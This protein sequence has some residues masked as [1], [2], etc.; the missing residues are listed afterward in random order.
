ML[1]VRGVRVIVQTE[2]SQFAE[3]T[4]ASRGWV[5]DLERVRALARDA[6]A[7]GLT[8]VRIHSRNDLATFALRVGADGVWRLFAGAG[9]TWSDPVPNAEFAKFITPASVPKVVTPER[10]L[11]E[12][13]LDRALTHG[14]QGLARVSRLL[15]EVLRQA[16]YETATDVLR[17]KART[18][19]DAAAQTAV[20]AAGMVLVA[21]QCRLGVSR[22]PLVLAVAVLAAVASVLQIVGVTLGI[23]WGCVL[24]VMIFA[25]CALANWLTGR[26]DRRL[27][28]P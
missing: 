20:L 7:H 24:L 8:E 11:T 28:Q 13:K 21:I 9:R 22:R 12:D 4:V 16:T 17:A 3:V 15:P 18:P 19:V 10:A 25:G 5:T 26:L 14:Q 23:G 2:E 6:S 1:R 27:Q